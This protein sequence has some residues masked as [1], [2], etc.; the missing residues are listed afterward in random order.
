MGRQARVRGGSSSA[1]NHLTQEAFQRGGDGK[2]R[3]AGTLLR[4]QPSCL[5]EKLLEQCLS[6]LQ[7]AGQS[8]RQRPSF[9]KQHPHTTALKEKGKKRHKEEGGKQLLSAYYILS[10]V[11]GTGF[12]DY[13]SP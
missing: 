1:L 13:Q 7:E 6:S 10:T 9:S 5:E 12:I 4:G 3:P 8:A 11:A 2:C